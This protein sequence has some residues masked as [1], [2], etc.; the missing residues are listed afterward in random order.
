ME[1]LN[2][3]KYEGTCSDCHTEMMI[4]R[5]D[6]KVTIFDNV[7]IKCPAC[8]TKF[9]LSDRQREIFKV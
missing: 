5:S 6:L 1:I 2:Q 8:N 9:Y 4:S 3:I 7:Y